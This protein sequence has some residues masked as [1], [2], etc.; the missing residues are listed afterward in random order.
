MF[1]IICCS[2][3]VYAQ[4]SAEAQLRQLE[5]EW[6]EAIVKKDFPALERILGDEFVYLDHVGGVNPKADMLRGLKNSEVTIDPF[7][8]EDVTVRVFGDTA[9][10]TGRFT[11]TV[12]LKE[13]SATAQFRYTDVYV[14]RGKSW[15]AVSAHG[16]RIP[17]KK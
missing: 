6:N 8:T 13:E 9:I 4:Q 3:H 16:S 10:V 7:E 12:R 11:Q 2:T 1:A 5:R 17:D 15:Q 14:R